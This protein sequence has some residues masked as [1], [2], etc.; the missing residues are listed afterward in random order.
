MGLMANPYQQYKRQDVMMA[1]PIELIVMLY[2][3]CIKQ[4]KLARM[5]IEKIDYEKT[6]V[7]MQKAQ[8]IIVELSVSLDFSYEISKEIMDIY[9][10]ILSQIIDININKDVEKLN[11]VIEIIENLRSTWI[12]VQKQTSTNAAGHQLAES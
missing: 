4:L 9:S 10:F 7:C 8:D 3:G 5:S 2:T 1:S 12:Q 6:N 11:K